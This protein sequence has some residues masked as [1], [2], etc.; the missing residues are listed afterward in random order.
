LP[1]HQTDHAIVVSNVV[2][3]IFLLGILYFKLRERRGLR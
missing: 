3:L 1:V 2:S